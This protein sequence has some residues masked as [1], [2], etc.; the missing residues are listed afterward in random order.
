MFLGVN[1][2]CPGSSQP[3]GGVG[4]GSTIAWRSWRVSCSQEGGAWPAGQAT[5]RRPRVVGADDVLGSDE[6]GGRLVLDHLDVLAAV[7]VAAQPLEQLEGS[8]A[9]IPVTRANAA[10]AS[11]PTAAR[12]SARIATRLRCQVVGM[13]LA[14]E[15]VR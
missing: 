11:T 13:A 6:L 3:S 15:H 4:G 10:G 8:H 2:A 9:Q 12:S 1:P 14:D 7:G 5:V